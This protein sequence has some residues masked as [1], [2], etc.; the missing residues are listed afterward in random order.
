MLSILIPTYNYDITH[1]VYELHKQ[2]TKA[3]IDFEIIALD[4]KSSNNIISIN[5]SINKLKFTNYELSEKNNGIAVT[6][7][8]LVNNAKYSWVL[9]ID[10]DVELRNNDFIYNYL[11]YINNHYDLFFGGF[12]YKNIKPHED[13]LL[14]WKYGKQ[15]EA[16]SASKRNKRP[17]KVTIAA[18]LLVKKSTYKSFNLNYIGKQ[19]AMDYYFGA[20][21]KETKSKVLHIDNQVYHLGIEKSSI[22]LEKK[23]KAAETLLNL[24]RKG[25]IKVHE[26]DL[27]ALYI[28]LKKIGLNYIFGNTFKI[29]KSI[30]KFNLLGK[31][32]K[33][34]LLQFYKILYICYFDLKTS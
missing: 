18:N 23:E 12:A 8:L 22:Y 30:L 5:S 11:K 33:V 29:F 1:L 4:D 26:N 17:Y 15:C 21:L 10:A 27:L 28:N 32:P 6:R 3:E 25:D 16:I 20:I 34:K 19:Y 9:L 14:R 13:F 31:H 2:A 7:Q 24:Y